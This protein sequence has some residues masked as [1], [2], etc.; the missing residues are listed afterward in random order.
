MNPIPFSHR[1]L[2]TLASALLLS[3]SAVTSSQ[4]KEDGCWAEFFQDSQYAGDHRR[5]DGPIKLDNLRDIQGEN[6]ETRIDS[7][8]VGPNAKV[9]VFENPN[10]K[11][12]IKE[13]GKYPE[14]LQ[15]LGLTEKDALEDSEL[16]FN[17]NSMI[18]DL[19][20]FNF[21]DKIKSLI[22]DCEN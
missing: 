11:L 13:M 4:A 8:K 10:F 5:F 15:S 12:T 7:L 17:A 16:I 3:V 6:W 2:A 19:S 1:G 20:D 18:H 14:L 9:T 21:H 22:I